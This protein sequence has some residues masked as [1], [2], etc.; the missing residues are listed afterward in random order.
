MRTEFYTKEE[1]E[2]FLTGLL[3]KQRAGILSVETII[4]VCNLNDIKIKAM[5]NNSFDCKYYNCRFLHRVAHR[6]LKVRAETLSNR[7]EIAS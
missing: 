3:V 6:D 1:V 7:T 2:S 4:K 5:S